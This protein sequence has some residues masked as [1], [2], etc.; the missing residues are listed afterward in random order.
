MVL[1]LQVAI[2]ELGP[3]PAREQGPPG[4]KGAK[5]S[6]E[7]TWDPNLTMTLGPELTSN[8]N[9]GS[10]AVMVSQDPKETG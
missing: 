4:L 5:V 7:S 1:D 9:R 8:L 6:V 3:G 10:Q 2:E